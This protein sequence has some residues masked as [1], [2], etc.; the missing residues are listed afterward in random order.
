M[1]TPLV[2]FIA[3]F[4]CTLGFAQHNAC[5]APIPVQLMKTESSVNAKERKC[6]ATMIYG[7]ARGES[8]RGMAAVAWTA[9]N[10]AKNKTICDVVLAPMQYSVFNDN[11]AL[12]QAA[13]SIDI[14]PRQKN[15]IDEKSWQTAMAVAD[16]VLS[17]KI[18][19]PTLGSTHYLAP[20]LM[21]KN[22][23]TYPK[24]ARQYTLVTVIDNHKFFKPFYPKTKK[25]NLVKTS[26]D[27]V[28]IS[29]TESDKDPV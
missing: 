3:A 11:P 2:L 29:R 5:Y 4:P 28:E 26:Q 13:L 19:D 15:P 21:K 9:K 24:W 1:R 22:G 23:W 14:A 27:L 7:E 12:R 6:L 8:Q 18:Q 17:G 16:G 10:R 25:D 20:S